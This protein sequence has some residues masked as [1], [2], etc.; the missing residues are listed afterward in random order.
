MTT[1][2][3]VLATIL[4]GAM[5]AVQLGLAAGLPY[6]AHVLGGRYPGVLPGRARMASAIAAALLVVFALVVLGRAG[7]VS[8][9]AGV[10]GLLG[11]ACWAIAAYLVLN[12]FGN[13]A[14]KSRLERTAFAATTAILA[15]LCGY[16][17]AAA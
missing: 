3:A 14:S 6:G 16:V 1:T 15:I 12:T 10:A 9:P 4:F 2:A 11:P 13:L 7:I 5:A 8:W 17:A